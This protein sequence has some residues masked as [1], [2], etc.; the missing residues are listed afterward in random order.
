[1]LG[2]AQAL[3]TMGLSFGSG[4]PFITCLTLS[5]LT[6]QSLR[7]FLSKMG[8]LYL[9]HRSHMRTKRDDLHDTLVPNRP[10]AREH[11]PQF[12]QRETSDLRPGLQLPC[13]PTVLLV[14]AP[15]HSVSFFGVE[16]PHL[17]CYKWIGLFFQASHKV[18]SV[19]TT[20]GDWGRV[21]SFSEGK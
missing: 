21:F 15:L 11:S 20:P 16:Y 8:E 2:N 6:S 17:E 5:K 18:L 14:M 1:M 12:S 7:F 9:L 3:K 13:L 19:A 4:V 10:L